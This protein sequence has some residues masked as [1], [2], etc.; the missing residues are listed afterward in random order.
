MICDNPTHR[1]QMCGEHVSDRTMSGWIAH[2][3]ASYAAHF[4]WQGRRF[5]R[6]VAR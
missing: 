5:A 4:P 2:R 1:C 6:V 3:L